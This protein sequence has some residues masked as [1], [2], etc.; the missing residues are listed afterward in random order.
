MYVNTRDNVID[1]D[2][3]GRRILRK[4]FNHLPIP[5][6]RDVG[7]LSV[8][9]TWTFVIDS[10]DY[11]ACLEVPTYDECR[12]MGAVVTASEGR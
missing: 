2:D 3:G 5:H 9:V 8:D 1:G 11:T 12:C 4:G 6:I 7:L 10:T